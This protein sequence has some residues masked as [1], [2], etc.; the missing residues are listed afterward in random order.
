MNPG[1]PAN[2]LTVYQTEPSL[3][4]G[5]TASGPEPATRMSLPA[6]AGAPGSLYSSTMPL[7]L[8]S[9]TNGAQPCALIASPVSSQIFVLTQPAT[10]PLPENHKVS[11]AS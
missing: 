5:I 9:R 6:C 2:T 11:S 10:G 1:V 4:C 8:V 3:G 7:P